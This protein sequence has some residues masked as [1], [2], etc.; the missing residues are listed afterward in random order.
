MT[1]MPAIFFGH[2]NPLNAL[3]RNSY[4]EGWATDR[5]FSAHALVQSSVFQLTGIFLGPL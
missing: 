5:R 2:G 4:T 1:A 3:L